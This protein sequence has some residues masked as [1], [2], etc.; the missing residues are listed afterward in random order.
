LMTDSHLEPPEQPIV[1]STHSA[2]RTPTTLLLLS[3]MSVLFVAGLSIPGISRQLGVSLTQSIVIPVMYMSVNALAYVAYHRIGPD[4]RAYRILDYLDSFVLSGCTAFL[5]QASGT[6]V[7]FF[8][9]FH[10]VQVVLTGFSG[11]S[12]IY[13]LSISVAPG[14]LALLFFF[15]GEPVS[16]FLSALS[17]LLGLLLY[18]NLG[19]YYVRYA[20]ALRREA[21]LRAELARVLVTRERTRISRDLHD[22][23][24]TELTALV[25]RVREISDAVPTGLHRQDIDELAERLRSVIDDI[26]NVVLSLRGPELGF[27]E[28]KALLEAR[29][30][31]LCT[32]KQ[33]RVDISGALEAAEV[34]VFRAEVLP[35]C[36]ELVQNA[37]AHSGAVHVELSVQVGST[38]HIRVHDDG[39]GLPRAAWLGSNG[40]LRGAR[41]RVEQLRGSVELRSQSSGTCIEIDVPRPLQPRGLEKIK[42][43][44]HS[45]L[46][47]RGT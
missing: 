38:L 31:E 45:R 4:S 24:A 26:R 22:S 44:T 35:I 11:F 2:Q 9:V 13:A 8:W 33:V 14:F 12:V 6:A 19:H 41:E 10:F 18:A 32:A 17:C 34:S 3:A 30:R 5:I 21:E 39:A 47:S 1:P 16:G 43:I 40:G 28:L 46:S 37:A 7:S 20:A 27:D 25:W 23:I 29:V 42:G 36:F 15:R